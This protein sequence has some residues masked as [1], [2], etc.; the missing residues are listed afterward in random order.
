M[1][2][3]TETH[4]VIMARLSSR[5]TAGRRFDLEFWDRVG[6]EGRFAAAWD[7]VLETLHLRGDDA[8]E[9]RLR[10]SVQSIQRG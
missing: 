8:S 10:R 3:G 1:E 5:E 4:R 9:P 7:M 2:R 6:P